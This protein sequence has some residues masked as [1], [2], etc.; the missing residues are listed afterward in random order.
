MYHY[1]REASDIKGAIVQY[2]IRSGTAHLQHGF[3]QASLPDGSR[4]CWR[5]VLSGA[6]QNVARL[7]PGRVRLVGIL[8]CRTPPRFRHGKM[9][10]L[11]CRLSVRQP[12]AAEAAVNKRSNG[13]R[14]PCLGSSGGI[15]CS[16]EAAK[17]TLV[18]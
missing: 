7:A 15:I 1:I 16:L 17:G 14:C 13:I 10:L 4:H 8:L 5:H 12:E 3:H 6:P 2:T 18:M 9:G 11:R